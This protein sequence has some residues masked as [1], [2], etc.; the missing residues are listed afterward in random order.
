MRVLLAEDDRFYANRLAE[1]LSDHGIEIVVAASTEDAIKVDPESY[2]SAIVDM[3]MPNDPI[4]SGISVEECRGGYMA[5]VALARRILRAK[6]GI[7]IVLMSG[8]S[9]L[10]EAEGW[11]ISHRI[12]L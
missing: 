2:E 6:P 3:N 7:K 12:P 8:D 10:D 11:A 1:L 4:V 9:W 5:G